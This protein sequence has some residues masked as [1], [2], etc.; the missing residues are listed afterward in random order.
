MPVYYWYKHLKKY[1]L[2]LSGADKIGRVPNYYF[3]TEYENKNGHK[4]RKYT[5]YNNGINRVPV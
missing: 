3:L 2:I 1:G 4:Y 5:Y